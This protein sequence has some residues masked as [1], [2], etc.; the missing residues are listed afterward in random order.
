MDDTN[1]ETK[2]LTAT[3]EEYLWGVIYFADWVKPAYKK[4]ADAYRTDSKALR[5]L[6]L[7]FC[8]KV[9]EKALKEA[10]KKGRAAAAFARCRKEHLKKTWMQ[11][12]ENMDEVPPDAFPEVFSDEL[13]EEP[14]EKPK[15]PE[16][17]KPPETA[18]SPEK[19]KPP[20]KPKTPEKTEQAEKHK[21]EGVIP[22]KR[23]TCDFIQ[24]L[25]NIVGG[26]DTLQDNPSRF[27]IELYAQGYS[28]LQI[29]FIL[30]SIELGM[31]KKEIKKIADPKI[32][33]EVMEK[34]RNMHLEGRDR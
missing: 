14:P 7:C 22:G 1:K 34:L 4:F 30:E 3:A 18:K 10:A 21:T 24:Q 6:Y 25:R 19:P 27:V 15:A 33:V 31:T 17:P 12:A 20:E 5:E 23:K 13:Q 29:N 8:D 16:K 2:E 28:D 26:N 32:P 11:E 9:P